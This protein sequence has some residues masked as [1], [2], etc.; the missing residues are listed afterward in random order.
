VWTPLFLFIDEG[1]KIAEIFAEGR[2]LPL[3]DFRYG[4][5][6]LIGGKHNETG[7]PRNPAIRS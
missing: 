7:N 5:M 4:W 3:S 6:V 1:Q 2:Y